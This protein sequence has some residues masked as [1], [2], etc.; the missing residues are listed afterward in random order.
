MPTNLLLIAVTLA[1]AWFGLSSLFGRR[2]GRA[3]YF[4]GAFLVEAVSW[5]VVFALGLTAFVGFAFWTA[6]AAMH[7]TALA[8]LGIGVAAILI[9]SF[10]SALLRDPVRAHSSRHPQTDSSSWESLWRQYRGKKVQRWMRSVEIEDGVEID[11]R[12]WTVDDS[13]VLVPADETPKPRSGRDWVRWL[14]E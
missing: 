7:P 2:S 4:G 9:A 13:G 10:L 5:L 14:L 3:D 12:L 11:G 1:G 8:I 6:A